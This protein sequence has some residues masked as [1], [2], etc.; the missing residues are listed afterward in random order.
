MA[1]E[2]VSYSGVGEA[3]VP[4]SVPEDAKFEVDSSVEVIWTDDLSHE[5]F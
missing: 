2:T 1:G 4:V 3:L 5:D